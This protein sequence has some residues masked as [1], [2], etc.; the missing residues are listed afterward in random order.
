[1]TQHV[2]TIAEIHLDIQTSCKGKRLRLVSLTNLFETL[3]PRLN[4]I[5][6]LIF[7]TYWFIIMFCKCMDTAPSPTPAFSIVSIG[8]VV[9]LYY[10]K[11]N[12]LNEV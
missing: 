4:A 3:Y 11:Q 12:K 1:M 7:L 8:N 10:L 6:I 9:L 2:Q 5:C